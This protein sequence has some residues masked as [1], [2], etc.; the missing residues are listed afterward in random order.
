MSSSNST[1]LLNQNIPLIPIKEN[2]KLT[3]L[4][5]TSNRKDDTNTNRNEHNNNDNNNNKVDLEVLFS[6]FHA[7]TTLASQSMRNEDFET[8]LAH[9]K[10]GL[11]ELNKYINC[12]IDITAI[13]EDKNRILSVAYCN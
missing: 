4:N 1:S 13:P 12:D 6:A 7:T 3:L 9:L 10:N 5:E 8:A 11:Y 2:M